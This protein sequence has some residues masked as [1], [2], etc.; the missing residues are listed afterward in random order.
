MRIDTPQILWHNGSEGNGK[1]APLYSVSLLPLKC[2][3]IMNYTTDGASVTQ[4]DYVAEVLATAGNNNEINLWKLTLPAT[5][6]KSSSIQ[7]RSQGLLL[8]PRNILKNVDTTKNRAIAHHLTLSRHERSINALAFSSKGTHLAAAGDS[9]LLLFFSVPHFHRCNNGNSN[10]YNFW[11][12]ILKQEKDLMYKVVHTHTEDVMDISWGSDERRLVVGTLDHSVL[13]FEEVS[14]RNGSIVTSA[15]SSMSESIATQW[16]CVYRNDKE[17]TQYVQ[18]VSFDP[19]GMYFA[20]QGSDRTVRV[21]TRKKA[22]GGGN[23]SNNKKVLLAVD[24]NA[25]LTADAALGVNWLHGKFEV[26]NK[27]KVLKYCIKQNCKKGKGKDNEEKKAVLTSSDQIIRKVPM[28]T[29]K[30]YHLFADES[31]VES[32]FR[33]LAWTVDGAFL[34]TPASIWQDT[35]VSIGTSLPTNSASPSFATYLFARHH[36]DRPYKV[37]SGLDKP[38]VVVRPNPVLYELPTEAQDNS[39]ENIHAFSPT[40]SLQINNNRHSNESL[41]Y[42]SIFAVLTLDTILI[43]DTYHTRPLCIARGLHFAG[44]TDCAWSSDGRNLVVS[45]TDGYISMLSFEE[46]ELGVPYTKPERNTDMMMSTPAFASESTISQ[47]SSKKHNN[48]MLS[49]KPKATL[50]PTSLNQILPCEPGQ[51]AKLMAPPTKK[52]RTVCSKSEEGETKMEKSALESNQDRGTKR[53]IHTNLNADDTNEDGNASVER[54]VLGGVTNLSLHNNL[55]R[56]KKRI[57][58][59]LL[60]ES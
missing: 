1:A 31:T 45:S 22:G 59:T 10:T 26:L 38:A 47:G 13:V 51:S 28:P 30:K 46:G 17:H 4:K 58:P 9:G 34:I 57:Q 3:D 20:S 42:R 2:G 16:T 25:Q 40:A 50:S 54:E 21:W 15:S 39:K 14:M 5:H 41:P 6:G 33:R 35:A 44:L 24:N 48:R 8:P 18:G 55:P 27:P 36:F 32:F 53:D 37:L 49:V 56:K 43:Y 52:A 23:K 19:Q 60:C 29:H 11:S 7:D 12:H